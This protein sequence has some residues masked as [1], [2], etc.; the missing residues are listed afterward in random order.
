MKEPFRK[1]VLEEHGFGEVVIEGADSI[2]AR[3]GDGL[4][5]YFEIAMDDLGRLEVRAPLGTLFLA[6]PSSN[7]FVLNV[8]PLGERI[9]STGD[10]ND[11][12][13]RG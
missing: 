3:F 7:T 13:D 6:A 12:T 4:H 8:R 10:H 1:R 5:E 2:R 11:R 9:K